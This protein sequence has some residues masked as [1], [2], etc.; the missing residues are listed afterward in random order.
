LTDSGATGIFFKNLIKGST[1]VVPLYCCA[2]YFP[3]EYAHNLP[4]RGTVPPIYPCP[5]K[6]PR[7]VRN[8]VDN[9]IVLKDECNG[10]SKQICRFCQEKFKTIALREVSKERLLLKVFFSGPLNI[11]EQI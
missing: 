10:R 11:S 8:V 2:L 1:T 6:M 9:N 5:L 7:S 3:G 4:R